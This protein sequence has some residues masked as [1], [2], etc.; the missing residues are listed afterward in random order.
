M[1]L[2]LNSD[3]ARRGDTVSSI[4]RD[5]GK[6]VGTITRAEKLLSK[7]CTEGFGLSFKA[8]DGATA[9]YLDIWTIKENGEPLRG[10]DLVNSIL[11]CTRTKV[12]DD[13]KITFDRWD[14]ES[15][16]L[17]KAT[18]DGYPVLMGKRI[19]L[20]LQKELQTHQVTGADVERLNVIGVFEASTGLTAQEILDQ[21]TKPERAELY[22]Q[23]L[24]RTPVRDSRKGQRTEPRRPNPTPA[25]DHAP[26]V[27]T[28]DDDI[29][30]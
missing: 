27:D 10:L 4:I 24:M 25:P 1:G 30:F 29:P 19:G 17:V 16:Q 3:N 12:A 28:F 20:F 21:K 26:V 18:S 9:N 23:T 7:N 6:Y 8:D 14:P 22:M 2:K 11:C 13:G 15:R 5:S